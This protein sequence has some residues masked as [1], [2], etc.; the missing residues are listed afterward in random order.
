MKLARYFKRLD[1]LF[2][3]TTALM[4]SFV[5]VVAYGKILNDVSPEN[6]LLTSF[7][8]GEHSFDLTTTSG[9]IGSVA[10]SFGFKDEQYAFTAKGNLRI[11]VGKNLVNTTV[12]AIANFNPLGQLG[13]V[14]VNVRA[15][16]VFI[17]VGT[18]DINP[19]KAKIVIALSGSEP[20]N[21]ET[22]LPGPINLKFNNDKTYSLEYLYFGKI[23]SN[24]SKLIENPA[25][26]AWIFHTAPSANDA[27]ACSA[28]S[29]NSMDISFLLPFVKGSF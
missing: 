28:Q 23:L 27:N 15:P 2:A 22:L 25:I 14:I 3:I 13:G 19:I 11:S 6:T 4:S 21:Y 20:F 18:K 8:A 10:T 17:R 1:F 9:C 29:Q 7:A 5:A 12:D 26:K 16:G 24:Y